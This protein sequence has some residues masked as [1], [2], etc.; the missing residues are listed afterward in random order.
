MISNGLPCVYE[1]K[2]PDFLARLFAPLCRQNHQL[3]GNAVFLLSDGWTGRMLQNSAKAG[4]PIATGDDRPNDDKT[5]KRSTCPA[6]VPVRPERR[7]TRLVEARASPG[8]RR[9]PPEGSN[10]PF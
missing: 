1:R 3:A 7:R 9:I 6:I 4:Q 10:A 2:N 5:G 8:R